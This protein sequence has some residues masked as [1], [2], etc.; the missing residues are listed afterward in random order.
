M[1]KKEARC[2]A[3]CLRKNL[4]NVVISNNIVDEIIKSNILDRFNNI[5]IYYPIGKEI[6]ILKLMEIYPNKKFYLPI[7]KDEI[8]FV[9]YN[10]GDGLID[11]PFNTKEPKG[12]IQNRDNID[13][14]IIPCVAITYDNKRIGYGKGYYDRYLNG[15]SGYK[16]GICYANSANVDVLADSYD[17]YLDM[18]F[19]G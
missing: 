9:E 17:V 13:C 2:Q 1:T 12:I 8:S 19:I 16:I 11:G 15:Y 5:G 6:S 14:F 10:I 18:K 7:T 4:D 3:L